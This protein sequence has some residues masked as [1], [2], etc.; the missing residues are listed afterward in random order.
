MPAWSVESDVFS[1]R[2]RKT[3]ENSGT[4]LAA[5]HTGMLFAVPHVYPV[6]HVPHGDPPLVELVELDALVDPLVEVDPLV[7]VEPPPTPEDDEVLPAPVRIEPPPPAVE[8]VV[9]LTLPPPP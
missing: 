1:I 4:P 9:L 2:M 5:R 7:D 6:G 8:V 3:C